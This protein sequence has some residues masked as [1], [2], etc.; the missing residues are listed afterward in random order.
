MRITKATKDQKKKE[1]EEKA[2]EAVNHVDNC[3]HK[4]NTLTCIVIGRDNGTFL[5]V[6]TKR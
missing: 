4:F 6:P 3:I 1:K 2:K 5:K